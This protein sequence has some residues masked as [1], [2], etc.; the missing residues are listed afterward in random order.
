MKIYSIRLQIG[1]ETRVSCIPQ[2]VAFDGDEDLSLGSPR[3]IARK[4]RNPFFAQII[5]SIFQALRMFPDELVAADAV[6]VPALDLHH[7]VLAV[8]EVQP[9]VQRLV[10][11]R[12]DALS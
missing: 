1:I 5:L 6:P 8:L 4:E 9:E 7:D 2:I 12:I 3:L 11:L 10:P